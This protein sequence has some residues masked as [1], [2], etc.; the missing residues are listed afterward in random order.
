[1]RRITPEMRRASIEAIVRSLNDA[2]VRYLVVGGLAV[3]M[4]GY[5]RFTDDVDLAIEPDPNA[6]R[7][8]AEALA[9]LGYAPRNPVPIESF[10][11]TD[12][13]RQW[14]DEKGMLVFQLTS[15]RHPETNVDL[16]VDI[17]FD[18]D[19]VHARARFDEI[20]P[21]LVMTVLPRRELMDMKRATDRPRDRD[22]LEALQVIADNEE[23]PD[24]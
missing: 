22:D 3:V 6:R 17:P 24:A 13:M 9:A 11:D 20:A 18:F 16:L 4:H 8:A 12:S 19:S 21:G 1:M 5:L 7:R 14:R 2:N 15:E 23:Q 10:A